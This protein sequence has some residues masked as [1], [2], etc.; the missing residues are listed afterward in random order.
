MLDFGWSE[1]LFIIVLA[2]FL[3]GPRDI[4]NVVYQAGRF[5]RRL[6]YMKYGLTKQFDAFMEQNDLNELRRGGSLGDFKGDLRSALSIPKI[7]DTENKIENTEKSVP[8]AALGVIENEDDEVAF[9]DELI[10]ERDVT[11]AHAG[12]QKHNAGSQL[13]LGLHPEMQKGK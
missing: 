9:H 6:Q 2:I 3:L 5:V 13:S 10:Q 8:G 11:P 12:V 1:F 4:P 7:E